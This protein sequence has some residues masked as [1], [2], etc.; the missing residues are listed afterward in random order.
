MTAATLGIMQPYFFPYLGHFQLI[1]AVD[2]W[3]V[4]DVVKY[5]RK[6]WMN[7]NRVLHPRGGWQYVTVPVNAPFGTAIDA[8]TVVNGPAAQRRILGQLEHYR[9][10][11]PFFPQVRDLVVQAFAT[12]KTDRLCELNVGSLMAVCDYLGIDFNFKVFSAMALDLPLID[13]AGGWALEISGA[14]GATRYINPPGGRDIFVPADW[15]ARGIELRFLET[16][17]H[18]YGCGPYAH[19]ENLSILDVLMWNEPRALVKRMRQ[20]MSL[21]P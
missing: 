2:R 3:I 21:V 17:S 8:V 7:R 11:A 6:S 18:L 5:N 1:L 10:K 4:F 13:H 12:A 19:I 15:E 20:T 14:L 9:G 16:Q